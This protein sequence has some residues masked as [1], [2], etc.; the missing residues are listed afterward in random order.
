MLCAHTVRKLKPGTFGE[1]QERFTPDGGAPAGWAG[2]RM[3]RNLD[4]PDQV[5]TFGFFDGSREELEANQA[6][7]GY[8]ERRQAADELVDA[9]VG[10]GLY[11]IV[12]KLGD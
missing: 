2:F 7:H 5:I 1:S 11:E 10:N 9:V 3:L 8:A 12:V 4:D 6:D